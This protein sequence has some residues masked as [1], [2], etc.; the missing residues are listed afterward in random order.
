MKIN[1]Y[2][3]APYKFKRGKV[4]ILLN[5]TSQISSLNFFKGKI[6]K[7]ESTKMCAIREFFEE[8]NFKVKCKE[9]EQYYYQSNPNKD[10]GIYLVDFNDKKIKHKKI[11]NKEIHKAMWVELKE[12]KNISKNQQKIF[13]NLILFFKSKKKY[14]KQISF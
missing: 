11:H 1:S 8:T 5:K 7:K 6:E 2:G 3:I 12:N 10:I 9:L 13:D 14:I 4:F